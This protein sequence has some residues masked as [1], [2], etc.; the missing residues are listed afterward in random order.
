[1]FEQYADVT[2]LLLLCGYKGAHGKAS[3][4]RARGDLTPCRGRR[5]RQDAAHRA[6]GARLP[7]Q[8]GDDRRPLVGAR[9]HERYLRDSNT[10][11]SHTCTQTVWDNVRLWQPVACKEL[12]GCVGVHRSIR[13]A[14]RQEC[15]ALHL[16]LCQCKVCVLIRLPLVVQ[17]YD[18]MIDELCE[19]DGSDRLEYWKYAPSLP[20]CHLLLLSNCCVADKSCS[21]GSTRTSAR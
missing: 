7:R 18:E 10:P 4:Q 2:F 12:S 15:G 3:C 5:Q 21:R 19:P 1:M 16:R 8:L 11:S 9:G 20:P 17:I 14:E 6:R 13:L